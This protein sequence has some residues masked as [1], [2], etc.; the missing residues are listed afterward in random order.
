LKETTKSWIEFAKKD[1]IAAEELLSN[2][3]VSNIVLFHSQQLVEKSL[4]AILE[5]KNIPIKKTHSINILLKLLP[6]NIQKDLAFD[7][8]IV[9]MIDEIYSNER[10]P[11]EFG[12]LPTGFPT[13]K[14]AKE[15]FNIAVRMHQKCLAILT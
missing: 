13:Q 1:L 14:K 4:K 5:E 10:Y 8:D 9:I 15:I 11:S 12:I 3:E 2:F 7:D 6:E